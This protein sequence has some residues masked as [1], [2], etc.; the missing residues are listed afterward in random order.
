[1]GGYHIYIKHCG[2]CAHQTSA[3]NS[4]ISLLSHIQPSSTRCSVWYK[5]AIYDVSQ[6]WS[7]PQEFGLASSDFQFWRS[8]FFVYTVCP[9]Y[10][11]VN[12]KPA[13]FRCFSLWKGLFRPIYAYSQRLRVE[14]NA[15]CPVIG[16]SNQSIDS[17]PE[18]RS[19]MV[20]RWFRWVRR[21]LISVTGRS[22]KCSL[23]MQGTSPW[24]GWWHWVMPCWWR[25]GSDPF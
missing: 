25:K 12:W 11:P 14:K 7:N 21:S 1:M 3:Q 22:C 6:T 5:H 18:G 17:L 10:I 20:R 9:Y 4:R 24:N 23:T 19:G 15:W 2:E 13:F 8:K 16:S